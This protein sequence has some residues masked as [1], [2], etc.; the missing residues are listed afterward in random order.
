MKVLILLNIFIFILEA[1]HLDSNI[2][3][4]DSNVSENIVVEMDESQTNTDKKLAE[5]EVIVVH[6]ESG[7]S[8][9][10]VRKK[11]KNADAE[12][13]AKVSVLKIVEAMDASGNIDMSKIKKD[14]SQIS[15][16]PL[17]HDWIK[18]KSGEWFKG[19]IRALYDDRLEFNSDEIGLHTFNFNNV[20]WV[21]SYHIISLNIENIATFPGILRIKGD[22]VKIIQGDNI[23]EFKR[24]DIVSFAPDGEHERNF[25]SGRATLS[26]D[27]RSGNINQYDYGSQ[28]NIQRRTAMS[29][30]TFDYL[31]RITTRDGEE[32]ANDNRLNQKYDRYLSRHFFWTPVFS[33]I[34][35]DFFRNIEKQITVGLG[36]GYTLVD[37]NK[38]RWS[39]SGGPALVYTKHVTV[40]TGSEIDNLSPALDFSTIY[41]TELNKITDLTATYRFT[42]A[43]KAAGTYKHHMLV[44]FE[45]ELTS[46]LDLDI[47]GVWDYILDPQETSDNII[48][49]P[50]DFQL[51]IGIGVEF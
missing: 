2:T 28:I 34:Y 35:S 38:V 8:D 14:F 43:D 9:D 36:A 29:R 10:E 5:E 49:D 40:Y 17:K 27:I 31:G 42:Y 4:V 18:T 44:T 51:L 45:N 41:E 46:W 22:D 39:I 33:E 13:Q 1:A 11:A 25:W 7:L 37:T 21:K 24:K 3:V 20:I 6:D 48:P 26:L 23:Y 32:T 15:P 30:L 50:N 16:K 47:T 19:E 12:K